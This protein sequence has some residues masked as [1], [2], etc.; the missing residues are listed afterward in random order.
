[1]LETG[2][3]KPRHNFTA[4]TPIIKGVRQ[5]K[6]ALILQ[7]VPTPHFN[8]VCSDQ[9]RIPRNRFNDLLFIE[10]HQNGLREREAFMITMLKHGAGSIVSCLRLELSNPAIILPQQ[11]LL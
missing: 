8:V 9:R 2:I 4:T 10:N 7:F 3:I 6:R 1:L 11:H 5:P